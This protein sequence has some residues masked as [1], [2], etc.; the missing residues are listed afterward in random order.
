MFLHHA[1]PFEMFTVSKPTRDTRRSQTLEEL[2]QNNSREVLKKTAEETSAWRDKCMERQVH[3]ETSA[4]RES[5]RKKLTKPAVQ[6][7]TEGEKESS[8]ETAKQPS[9]K[10]LITDE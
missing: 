7:R 5:M 6:R 9:T 10:S 2:F 3:G 4:W 1:Q 8:A